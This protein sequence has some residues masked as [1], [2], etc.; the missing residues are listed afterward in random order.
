[1]VLIHFVEDAAIPQ[2]KPVKLTACFIGELRETVPDM[3][4]RR[5]C[6]PEICLV[7]QPRRFNERL[8]ELPFAFRQGAR[9]EMHRHL[10]E[11]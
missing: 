6:L 5:I 10:L 1:V 7:Y 9:I 4:T 3:H 2:N 11:S 8:Q